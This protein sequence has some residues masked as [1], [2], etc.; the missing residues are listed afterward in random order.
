[1]ISV[2]HISPRLLYV[3]PKTGVSFSWESAWYIPRKLHSFPRESRIYSLDL[4]RV[5]FDPQK[6]TRRSVL[7]ASR[8]NV[9]V[10]MF[11]LV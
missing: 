8:S 7:K 10:I 2:A 6:E 1:M 11:K 9:D 5:C 4:R 3:L